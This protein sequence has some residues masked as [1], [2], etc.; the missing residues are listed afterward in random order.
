MATV[1]PQAAHDPYQALRFRDFRLIFIARLLATMGTQMVGVAVGWELYDRTSSYLALGLV[2][3]VEV[4]PIFLLALPAGHIADRYNRKRIM[5][6]TQGALT[7]CSFGLAAVSFAHGEIALMYVCLF[8]IGITN[9]FLAPAYGALFSQTVPPESFQNAATWSSSSWQL[10]AV[11]GPALGG[12]VIGWQ[13]KAGLVYLIDMLFGITAFGLVATIKGR[14]IVRSIEPATRESL[15][16]GVN[17]I[18]NTKVI[19]AAIT[20]D[21]FAVL[22]GGAVALLPVYAKD[23]LGVGPEGLGWLRAAPSIGAV[24]MAFT[25][26]H[27][28]PFERAGRTLIIAVIGF[29][30]ATIVFGLSRSF[31]LS[32][33]MLGLLGALDNISVVIRGTLLLVRTPDA[34]RGRISAVNNM[35]LSASNELGGFE[36]GLAA[37]LFGPILA[38]VGGGVM[39]ILVVLTV[40]AMWP[41]MRG[42]GRLSDEDQTQRS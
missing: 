13:H 2:G 37:Q 32:L 35:F 38:V 34:M 40:A 18:W 6:I 33:A 16:A 5:M 42:L 39:T 23:I 3:L 21:M 1:P 28:K 27:R 11:F 29:G 7:L 36:S 22:F 10:A 15:A 9:A 17:F 24:L 41:E 25:L 8:G 14:E 19:L 26:A 20:L 30:L 4:I 12:L 31:I